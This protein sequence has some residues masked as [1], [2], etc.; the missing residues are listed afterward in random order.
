M[1]HV[2]ASQEQRVNGTTPGGMGQGQ[3]QDIV[4]L[5]QACQGAPIRANSN[6]ELHPPYHFRLLVSPEQ[7]V[8]EWSGAVVNEGAKE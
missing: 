8:Q 4:S 5:A 6:L 7:E 2:K 3:G 1:P